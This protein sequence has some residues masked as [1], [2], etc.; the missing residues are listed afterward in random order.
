M[1]H[2]WNACGPAPAPRGAALLDETLR[3]GLQ[4]PSARA[5]SLEDKRALVRAADGLGIDAIDL[6][7]PG[8]GPRVASDV[9]ALCELVRDEGLHIRPACA[10][11]TLEADIA[12]IIDIAEATGVPIEI[13]TFLGASPIRAWAEGWSRDTMRRLVR[14]AVRLGVAA[15]LPV[16]FVTEDTVRAHPDVLADLYRVALEEGAGRIVVCDTVGHATPDGVRAIVTWTR[17]L[18]E[19]EGAADVGI[20]FHGH[21][22]RGLALTCSLAALE[23]GADRVH[24]TA[25]GIGERVGNC[26]MD[27]LL[28]NLALMGASD[29]DLSGLAAWCRHVAR[30]TGVTIPASHPV[31]GDDAFRTATGVH[32]AA[33]VKALDKGGTGAA[34]LVYSGVPA[35]L[36]GRAQDIVVG[37][38]SGDANIV[39]WLARRQLP[40]NP[41]LVA[42][43]RRHAKASDH[44]VPDDELLAV[45]AHC[46]TD[47]HR[48]LAA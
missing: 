2:D 12:P 23:A 24:G 48:P 29:R 28:V 1:I 42:E 43:L 38:L 9:R 32:A 18:L 8:A 36:V 21:N 46:L 39:A 16:S 31:V 22:D 19:R 26:A 20:D 34:D 10:G 7:L 30:A 3:D 47:V 15:G 13:L 35:E 45:V 40:T 11:R 6:G 14:D 4:S 17:A 25:L 44:V 5:P 41:G 33:I 37:P 27:Q